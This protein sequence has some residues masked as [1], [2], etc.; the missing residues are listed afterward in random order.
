MSNAFLYQTQRIGVR[1]LSVKE[2]EGNYVHWFGDA[3]VCAFNSHFAYPK[4]VE[5]LRQFIAQLDNTSEHIVWAIYDRAEGVHVGNIGLRVFNRIDNNA[6]LSF[7]LG[8]KSYWGR[9]YGFEAGQMMLGHGFNVLNLQ[10]IYCG[11]AGNNVPMQK[12]AVKLGFVQEG[13]RRNNL[14]L[15]GKYEDEIEYG[16]LRSEFLF[17]QEP[18]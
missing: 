16:L 3:Q 18:A 10:R 7:L 9:G 1:G 5:G 12:L 8:E 17:N 6:E 14:Y 15:W 2:L 13:V 4:S 11:C